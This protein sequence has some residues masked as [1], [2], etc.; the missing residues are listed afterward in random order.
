MK[1]LI[2]IN[3]F[4]L[5]CLCISTQARAQYVFDF[6]TQCRQ[7]YQEII[8]LR[9]SDGQ[10][11]ISQEKKAHPGNLIPYLLENYIDFFELFFNE[12]P[13]AYKLKSPNEEN[14]LALMEK[15]PANSPFFLFSK[16]IIHFQWAAVK[17][18]F[19][20]N[21]EAGWEFRRSFLQGKENQKNFPGF[22]ANSMLNGAMEVAAGTIPDGYKW[23]AGLLGIRGNIHEGME[24]LHAFIGQKDTWAEIFRDESIFY[25]LYLE[26]YI[27]NRREEVF[28][29]IADL[30][31]DLVNNHLFAYLAA[32]LGVNAQQAGYAEKILLH[33]NPG[34]GYMSMPLWDMEM[35]Y[36]RQNHLE[37]D[38]NIYFIRFLDNF[39]GRFYVKDVLQKLSWYYYLEGNQQKANEYRSLILKKG[40]LLSEADKQAE[41]EALS[42]TWPNKLLLKARLLNDGGY[43]QEALLLLDGKS[44]SDFGSARERLAFSYWLAR[45]YDD[46]GRKDEAIRN[47]L[48]TL[49]TGEHSQEYYAARSALQIG[50]I[51]ESRGDRSSAITYFKKCIEIKDHDYKN[52]LDQKAKA[53]IARCKN[54]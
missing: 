25:Y 2:K 35:G 19:G 31:L 4:I 36:A 41:K 45:I 8:Q 39:K 5:F 49:R 37:K 48:I 18:K 53:G 50:Y 27:E 22:S 16:S 1:R 47:Y 24:Q 42:G 29:Q 11:L 44:S 34:P 52:S 32:N 7:A 33:R 13:V 54:E 10:Q 26:F 3:A 40:A 20:Y 6:N 12:D 9:L 17:I 21:W 51:Y 23:L 14:R 28:R 46:L 30:R 15:G 38:A 43:H